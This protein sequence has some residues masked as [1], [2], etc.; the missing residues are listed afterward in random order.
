M[1]TA[2]IKHSSRTVVP[3]SRADA[4]HVPLGVINVWIHTLKWAN[5][6]RSIF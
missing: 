6:N 1:R 2:Y 4:I 3:V 5:T